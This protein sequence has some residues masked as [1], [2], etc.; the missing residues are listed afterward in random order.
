MEIIKNIKKF[1]SREKK[2]DKGKEIWKTVNK[3]RKFGKL[4]VPTEDEFEDEPTAL[5][6]TY[7]DRELRNRK[8]IKVGL[9][10]RDHTGYDAVVVLTKNEYIILQQ[11]DGEWKWYNHDDIDYNQWRVIHEVYVKGWRVLKTV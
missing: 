9:Y 3:L 5:A 6:Y 7:S 8:L 11:I 4:R 10:E 1:F 2:E